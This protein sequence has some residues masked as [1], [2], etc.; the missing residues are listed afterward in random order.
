MNGER[1]S[2]HPSEDIFPRPLNAPLGTSRARASG[3]KARGSLSAAFGGARA[4]P[5]PPP[6][7]LPRPRERLRDARALR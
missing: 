5:S 4:S 1:F 7:P 3:P 2:S 6:L